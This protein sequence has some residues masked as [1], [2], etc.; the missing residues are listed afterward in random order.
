MFEIVAVDRSNIT[1]DV[2]NLVSGHRCTSRGLNVL[3]LQLV[4]LVYMVTP[5][6]TSR[7]GVGTGTAVPVV[8][9]LRNKTT[10]FSHVFYRF[11]VPRRA[12]TVRV[13]AGLVEFTC[14]VHV[15]VHRYR[16]RY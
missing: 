13:S 3:V 11:F 5:V 9:Y 1:G 14:E 8:E 16:Y 7:Y 15:P 6:P 2:L 4:N 12:S 10:T